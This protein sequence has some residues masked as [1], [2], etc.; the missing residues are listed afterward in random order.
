MK[1]TRQAFT[2]VLSQSTAA[3]YT[4]PAYSIIDIDVEAIQINY[5]GS[6]SGTFA[7]EGSVDFA[8][9]PFG[10][11]TN[12]GNWAN[13]YYSVNGAAPAASVA[14]PSNPSPIIFD[15]YGTGVSYLRVVYTGSGT[16]TFTAL[17]TGK[18]L[19]D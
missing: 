16:G 14:V 18:R 8:E 9:D 10:N 17:V 1:A 7:I 13:L 3:S 15:T 2:L 12:A 6:P 11:I 19:G 5:T 4:S